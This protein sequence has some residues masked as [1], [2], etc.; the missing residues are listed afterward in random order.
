MRFKKKSGYVW[1]GSKFVSVKSLGDTQTAEN[2]LYS[3]L[4]SCKCQTWS[5]LIKKFSVFSLNRN[6]VTR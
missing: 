4:N 2:T 3:C 5:F 1:T 6:T